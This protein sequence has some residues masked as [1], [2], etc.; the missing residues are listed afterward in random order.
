M[1]N[2][3]T[4]SF[5]EIFNLGN[6]I[7]FIIAS[8]LSTGGFL[9]MYFV[10]K[11]SKGVMAIVDGLFIGCVI[12]LGITLFNV[13]NYFGAFDL[14]AVGF[15]NMI[16]VHFRKDFDAKYDS[17]VDYTEGKK[18]KR[19]TNRFSFMPYLFVALIYLTLCL[20]FYFVKYYPIVH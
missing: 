9:I 11:D 17:V 14:L 2:K 8:V 13:L 20:I 10:Y 4:F 19:K 16:N 15:S 1:E 6:L 3:K 12:A 7:R 18:I 5:K